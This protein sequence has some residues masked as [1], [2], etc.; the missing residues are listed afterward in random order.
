MSQ[1]AGGDITPRSR[2]RRASVGTS[3]C[4]R[5]ASSAEPLVSASLALD[6]AVQPSIGLLPEP[7]ALPGGT[8]GSPIEGVAAEF[9]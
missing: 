1:A 9:L 7:R 2:N 5:H 8:E 4:W 6:G 3:P